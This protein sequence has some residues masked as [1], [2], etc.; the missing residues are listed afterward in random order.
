MLQG[1]VFQIRALFIWQCKEG[2]RFCAVL[3]RPGS[4]HGWRIAWLEGRHARNESNRLFDQ[5]WGMLS[6]DMEDRYRP[7]NF[8]KID[9][10]ELVE[11]EKLA[12]ASLACWQYSLGNGGVPAEEVPPLH[13]DIREQP[14]D[15]VVDPP[16]L[17]ERFSLFRSARIRN[18]NPAHPCHPRKH[19][20]SGGAYQMPSPGEGILALAGLRQRPQ[21]A[22]LDEGYRTREGPRNPKDSYACHS[23]SKSA[24]CHLTEFHLIEDEGGPRDQS[25]CPCGWCSRRLRSRRDVQI[26]ASNIHLR[27]VSLLTGN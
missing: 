5:V 24:R 16:L 27:S 19:L 25:R 13:S 11:V 23:V 15:F 22:A 7:I 10:D 9:F 14:L 20:S 3:T 26:P 8:N 17:E 6:R 4:N 1:R 21:R 2:N 18:I 12:W